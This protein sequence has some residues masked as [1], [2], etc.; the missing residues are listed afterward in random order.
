MIV[1]CCICGNRHD[2]ITHKWF[3]P[4]RDDRVRTRKEQRSHGYCDKCY[5]LN[6]KD[7]GFTDKEIKDALLED[8]T[9]MTKKGR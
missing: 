2:P 6:M 9:S 5:L 1:E 4:T 8:Y 3:T 7:N